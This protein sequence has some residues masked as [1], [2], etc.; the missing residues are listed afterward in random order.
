MAP[1]EPR[2]GNPP[3][4][5]GEEHAAHPAPLLG[6]GF[7]KTGALSRLQ[8]VEQSLPDPSIPG[9]RGGGCGG[10]SAHRSKQLSWS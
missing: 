7:V 8:Q 4:R 2:E 5:A 6:E 9:K 10:D 1:R 3:L